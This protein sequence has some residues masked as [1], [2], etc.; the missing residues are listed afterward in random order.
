M[1]GLPGKKKILGYFAILFFLTLITLFFALEFRYLKR[2][3]DENEANIQQIVQGEVNSYLEELQFQTESAAGHIIKQQAL[4]SPDILTNIAQQDPRI[5]AIYLLDGR[6]NVLKSTG[7][8][9]DLV[10]HQAALRNVRE[11]YPYIYGIHDNEQV[12]ELGVAVPLTGYEGPLTF[13]VVTYD[14]NDYKNKIILNYNT[15]KFKVALID[16]G[17]HPAVWPFAQES[18]ERFVSDRKSFKAQNAQY[19]VSRIDL[20]NTN[21]QAYFFSKYNYFDAYRI[22][23]IML[24]L[25]ALYFLIYQFIL[26]L[27]NINNINAYFENIDFNIFNN[28]KEGII[29]ANKFNKI[30][31]TNHVVHEIFHEKEI[32]FKKTEL[33]DLIGPLDDP[34]TRVTL[35]KA[36]Q[37]LEI[38]SS[39]I[40]KNGKLLGSLVVIGFSHEKEKLCGNA[41]GKIVEMLPDGVVFVDK[42]NKIVTFNMM[43]RYYLGNIQTEKNIDEVNAELATLIENNI[44]SSSPSRAALSYGGILCE[45]IPVY[46]TSGFY[47]GMVLFLKDR[48]GSE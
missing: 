6:G 29:I 23:T 5:T 20:E 35:K 31:Y 42:D 8:K 24:L 32:V 38:I 17:G 33:K 39:P 2:I 43:A 44:G 13:M 47:S 19:A 12:D 4:S 40:F 22:I 18:F 45:L 21:L 37:L 9:K 25:F 14:I 26:E 3:M 30:V 36:N 10:L 28:L 1:D 34:D 15:D 27:L 48:A 46:D 16:S 7:G 11:A 41:L